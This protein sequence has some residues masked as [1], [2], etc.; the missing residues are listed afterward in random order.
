MT[1]ALTLWL[2]FALS[3]GAV[4]F[5]NPTRRQAIA[6]FLVAAT[7]LPA[8][9]LPLGHATPILPNGQLTVLGARIDI[10]QAIYV[11]VDGPSVGSEPRLL[12]LP[13][14]EQTA[15]KLQQAMDGVADGEGTVTM[16][17]GVDGS[18]GFSEETPPPEPAKVGETQI[19]GSAP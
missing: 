4:A 2:A 13:Y 11:M 12:V 15:S 8:A 7:T 17:Q 19:I 9:F 3:I 18:P 16:R 5:A 14:S 1:P 10:G 6:F